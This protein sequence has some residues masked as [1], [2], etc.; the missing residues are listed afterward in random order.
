MRT[1]VNIRTIIE[2]RIFAMLLLF[3]MI[4]SGC[5]SE[6]KELKVVVK[7]QPEK[8]T[9]IA[10]ND[11]LPS[12][13]KASIDEVNNEIY[14]SR[15]NAI[16]RVAKQASP[17]IVGLTVTEVVE[18][19]YRDPLIDNPFFR[20]FFRNRTRNRTRKYEVHGLGSGFIISPDGYILTNHH[21]AGNAS[22]II[23]TMTDG[24]KYDAEIIGA[25]M[26][27][28]VALL[29][30]EGHN[31]PYLKLGNSDGVIV[32]EWAIAFGNP[33]G[34]FDMNAKP[35]VTVGVVSNKGLNF[36]NE[37][38]NGKR[39]YKN[40]IQTDAAIS[41]GNSGGPLL[42]AEGDV[43]GINTMIFST[44]QSSQGSGSIGIGFSIPVNRV[45]RIVNLL[46]KNKKIDRNYIVGIEIKEMDQ[47]IA[48]YLDTELQQGVVIF[49]VRRD[50]PADKAG[51]A[52]GDIIMKIDDMP[53]T[54]EEDYWISVLDAVVGQKLKFV[55]L[56]DKKILDK[57]VV[58]SPNKRR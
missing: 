19:A 27:S 32:G 42:N 9:L 44:A 2:K 6:S 4:A 14:N 55:I 30:I 10:Q 38:R 17:A 21:V 46:K 25:D 22:K 1:I 45:K 3:L 56:R 31:M 12:E 43:I 37:D 47:Q 26:V 35:T 18:V 16:T 40:M 20:H 5:R 50:S 54:K 34:L 23:V 8:K 57:Y 28:D 7:E 15:Q 41:S 52:P 36:I 49:G 33:F 53:I 11:T 13:N 58:L 29:K 24:Q 39:V 48:N 51:L